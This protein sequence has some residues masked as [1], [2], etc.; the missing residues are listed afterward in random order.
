MV[1]EL[2]LLSSLNGSLYGEGGISGKRTNGKRPSPKPLTQRCA[3]PRDR[4]AVAG[5]R[6][7]LP[8]HGVVIVG[9][10]RYA[11]RHKLFATSGAVPKTRR[12]FVNRVIAFKAA[13]NRV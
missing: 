5:L 8:F 7:E 13:S 9:G 11:V 12:C 6:K 3:S 1:N 10:S 4:R 2:W